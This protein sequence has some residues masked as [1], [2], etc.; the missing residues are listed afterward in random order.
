MWIDPRAIALCRRD[1][2]VAECGSL[3]AAVVL[4]LR[5]G[6]LPPDDAYWWARILGQMA[7]K[8][9]PPEYPTV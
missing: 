5:E 7:R 9:L 1:H 3:G 6:S 2:Y 8:V 4:R